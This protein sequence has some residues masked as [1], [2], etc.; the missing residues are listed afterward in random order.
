MKSKTSGGLQTKTRIRIQL[1]G[2]REEKKGRNIYKAGVERERDGRLRGGQGIP[3]SRRS[4]LDKRYH[5]RR[6]VRGWVG[7]STDGGWVGYQLL[8]KTEF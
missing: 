5:T 7:R 8:P 3:K 1:Q 4:D 2:G 6:S